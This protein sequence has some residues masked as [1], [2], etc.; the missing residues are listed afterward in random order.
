MKS[1]CSPTKRQYTD[2]L[3]T[4]SPEKI[5]KINERYKHVIVSTPNPNNNHDDAR[6]ISSVDKSSMSIKNYSIESFDL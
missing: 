5:L 1:I 4:S 6:V 2:I 3:H